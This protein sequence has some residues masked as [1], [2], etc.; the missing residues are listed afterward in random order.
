MAAGLA[1]QGAG[2]PSEALALAHDAGRLRLC[3][4][5]MGLHEKTL[6]VLLLG[7]LVLNLIPYASDQTVVQRYLAVRD[8]RA[9]R[10]SIFLNLA[11]APLAGVLFFAFGSALF[12]F[13][14][15]TPSAA[16][17]PSPDQ[18]VPWFLAQQLPPGLAGLVTA[19]IFAAAMS[20]LDSSMNSAAAV[21]HHDFGLGR[22]GRALG[23]SRLATLVLGALGTALALLIASA[24]V[25]FVFDLFNEALGFFGGALCAVFLL[26]VLPVRTTPRAA[27]IG[28]FVGA[29]AAAAASFLLVQ[30][31]PPL[32]D[33][34]LVGPV[35]FLCALVAALAANK[36]RP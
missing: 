33:G 22:G 13:Y 27:G 10:R 36:Q 7:T 34:F 23:I 25:Q 12:A 21:L 2:G 11:M 35:G 20:S 17:P 32:L 1:V 3:K 8:E 4:D 15:A 29:A 16:P 19:A 31:K 18:V 28:L 30:P 14:R 5:G 9:A 26:A 6:P 24:E